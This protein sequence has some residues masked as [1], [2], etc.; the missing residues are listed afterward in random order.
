MRPKT[1]LDVLVFD[2]LLKF[3]EDH[4]E[5]V[6]KK[7]ITERGRKKVVEEFMKL[8]AKIIAHFKQ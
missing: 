6:D 8:H 4:L 5:I 2:D 7:D 1:P 3:Q